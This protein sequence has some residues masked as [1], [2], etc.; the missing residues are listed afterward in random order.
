MAAF[1]NFFL[2]KAVARGILVAAPYAAV[3]AVVF[4]VVGKLY[5]P[6]YKNLPAE[7]F[8]CCLL[9]QRKKQVFMLR[10]LFDKLQGFVFIK[11]VRIV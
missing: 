10:A 8:L 2:R 7:A 6:A 9:R 3:I 11:A 4:A 5:Q 1:Q